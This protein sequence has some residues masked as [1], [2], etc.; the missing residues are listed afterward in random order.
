MSVLPKNKQVVFSIQNYI[1]DT[2]EIFFN[3]FFLNNKNIDLLALLKHF[4]YISEYP[5]NVRER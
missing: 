4:V 1:R 3:L 5:I 2:S